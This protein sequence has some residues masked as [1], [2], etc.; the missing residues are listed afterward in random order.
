MRADQS[1]L[2][3]LNVIEINKLL[4]VA[5]TGC[6]SWALQQGFPVWWWGRLWQR[7]R[8]NLETAG[9]SS[10]QDVDFLSSPPVTR[11]APSSAP[12]FKEYI[13]NI[14]AIHHWVPCQSHMWHIKQKH[15]KLTQTLTRWAMRAG[16]WNTIHSSTA[17]VS[18]SWSLWME[19]SPPKNSN[20]NGD[21]SVQS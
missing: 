20:E 16:D 8:H 1:S 10:P 3:Q 7:W 18:W 11:P 6:L 14:I 5:L 2:W 13:W 15:V 19:I 21:T 12:K 9:H 17:M 4:V